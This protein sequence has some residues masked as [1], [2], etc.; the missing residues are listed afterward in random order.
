M[1]PVGLTGL[2]KVE[3][4]FCPS[5]SG[6]QSARFSA[7]VLPALAGRPG[8]GGIAVA[9]GGYPANGDLHSGGYHASRRQPKIRRAVLGEPQPREAGWQAVALPSRHASHVPRCP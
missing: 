9:E 8:S 5:T 3:T 2:S 4:I 1:W 7:I 6:A